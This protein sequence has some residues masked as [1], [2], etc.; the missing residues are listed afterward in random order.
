MYSSPTGRAAFYIDTKSG[1]IQGFLSVRVKLFD[2]S[3]T[4]V[5]PV[6]TS[7]LM[8]YS[9]ECAPAISI[10]FSLWKVKVLVS[11]LAL[12]LNESRAFT[13]VT[14]SAYTM[15]QKEGSAVKAGI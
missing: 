1:S 10:S 4:S 13:S 15:S 3:R 6:R 7:T 9:L 8:V 2:S 12:K 11:E 5:V 14:S